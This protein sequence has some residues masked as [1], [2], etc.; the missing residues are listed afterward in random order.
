MALLGVDDAPQ[1]TNTDSLA[2]MLS[3][4]RVANSPSEGVLAKAD[5]R[6][7]DGGGDGDDDVEEGI[8]VR[9]EE[10]EVGVKDEEEVEDEE[11]KREG[12]RKGEVEDG[13]REGKREVE[14]GIE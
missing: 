14:F 8:K 9:E 4:V 7:G 3:A 11:E 2:G 1:M 5:W 6:G 12:G 13:G 10:D